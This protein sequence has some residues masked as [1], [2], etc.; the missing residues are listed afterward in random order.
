MALARV[1][2][3]DGVSSDRIAEMQREMEGNERPDNVPAKEILRSARPGGG[4]IAGSSSSR[5]KT[6]TGPATQRS[7]QCRPATLRASG[8]R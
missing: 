6:T 5:T 7:A 2:S 8:R 3:F 4:E 1:V